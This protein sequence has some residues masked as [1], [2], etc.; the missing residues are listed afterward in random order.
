MFIL[1]QLS[2][3]LVSKLVSI[4]KEVDAVKFGSF[5]LKDGSLS[6]V[7]IDLR[8]LSNYPKEF[9][10]TVKIMA[11]YIESDS[12]IGQFDGIV[13]PPLAGIPLGVALA[14][15]M[16][17]EFYLA[18]YQTKKH[19]TKK[20]IEGDISKKR[21]LLV[22]DVFTAGESKVPLVNEIRDHGG[23]VNTLSVVINRSSKKEKLTEFEQKHQVK[24]NYLLSLEDLI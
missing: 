13:A 16:N 9:Q 21:I 17:K 8:I 4:F 20:L 2:S 5:E 18:R 12:D 24:V 6:K 15:E 11:S 22:D 14:L 7:F 1:N 10:E 23:I 19:G 3:S